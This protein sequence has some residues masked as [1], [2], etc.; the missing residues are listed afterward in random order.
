MG[1]GSPQKSK[2]PVVF[3]SLSI[4]DEE[5]GSIML[6]GSH[7][8]G[9]A[10]RNVMHKAKRKIPALLLRKFS[11][12]VSSAMFISLSFLWILLISVYYHIC[13]QSR[14]VHLRT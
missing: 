6:G 10:V 1:T 9:V 3:I 14:E 12:S 4:E 5:G 7:Q 8:A 13:H 11:C 2:G